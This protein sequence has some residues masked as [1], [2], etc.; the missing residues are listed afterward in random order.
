MI[1]EM[2]QYVIAMAD[3]NFSLRLIDWKGKNALMTTM[4]VVAGKSV[5]HETLRNECFNV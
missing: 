1:G 4:S 2:T 3:F 5:P